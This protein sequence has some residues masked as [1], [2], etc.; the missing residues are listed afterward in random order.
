MIIVI[1]ILLH[2][3]LLMP[4]HF[5]SRIGQVNLA[6]KNDIAIF[7]KKTDFD[8]KLKDLNKK[9]TSNKTKHIETEKKIIYLTK[10]VA[11]KKRI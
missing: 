4:E 9:C 11:L 10:K 2:K 1:G 5:A 8:D 3:N 6:S 7:V